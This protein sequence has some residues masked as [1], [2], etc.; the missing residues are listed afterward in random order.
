[1][2]RPRNGRTPPP[3][4]VRRAGG[5][6]RLQGSVG[7]P[8]P[9][10][11][12]AA[13]RALPLGE[14]LRPGQPPPDPVRGVAGTR[15]LRPGHGADEFDVLRQR[16]VGARQLRPTLSTVCGVRVA[17]RR[18]FGGVRMG[19]SCLRADRMFR[20]RFLGVALGPELGGGVLRDRRVRRRDDGGSDHR[21]HACGRVAFRSHLR[22]CRRVPGGLH[23]RGSAGATPGY[24]GP[25][26]VA[27]RAAEPRRETRCGGSPW[28]RYFLAWPFTRSCANAAPGIPVLQSRILA[29]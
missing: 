6:P 3:P 13:V 9:Q 18:R 5:L 20:V 27:R 10:R 4:G 12:L 23:L 26:D 19:R 1:M 16:D 29:A 15:V 7:D 24:V 21:D 8:L 25:L 2:V 17:L 22:W 14:R 11:G 28:P